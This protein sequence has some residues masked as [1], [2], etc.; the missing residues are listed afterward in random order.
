MSIPIPRIEDY[1]I[2]PITGFLPEKQPLA[3]LPD[4]YSCWEAA[5]SDLPA[6]IHT[7]QLRSIVDKM[8]VLSVGKLRKV[9]EQRRAYS[10][11]G[12][13]A[14]A[15]VWSPPKVHER[16]PRQIAAPLLE[17]SE[18]LGLPPVG[19]FAGLCLWNF[20]TVYPDI[21]GE[22]WDLSNLACITL[23]TG[24]YDEAWFY[25]L[26]VAMER[27]GGPCIGSGLA[28]I[29]AAYRKDKKEV[30]RRLS[31]LAEAIRDLTV[32]LGK[33]PEFLDPYVF[34]HRLR[35]Y[36]AGWK[37]MGKEGLPNGVFYG[38]ETE[39]RQ[40]SGGSNGQSSLVQVLDILLNVEHHA[41]GDR[42]PLSALQGAQS[43][44]SGPTAHGG[45]KES[46]SSAFLIE[47]RNYM[48]R[49]HRQFLVDLEQVANIRDFVLEENDQELT[50]AYDGALMALRDFRS[51]H[52]Q[53]VM[54]YISLQARKGGSGNNDAP[55]TQPQENQSPEPSSEKAQGSSPKNSMGLSQSNG[56]RGTG[57]TLLMPFLKQS[58]DEV[59]DAAIGNWGRNI[60]TN[61]YRR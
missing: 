46:K 58:R 21:P 34:Y 48:P 59:S 24:S 30:S 14:H 56:E 22:Y 15:Y 53:I 6:L 45:P 43:T 16:L 57:G 19:T 44:H 20:R 2:S 36:L 28:A 1:G 18:K 49:E 29:E 41:L 10:V 55:S 12:F 11:L 25:V 39:G 4:E 54:R 17:I 33:M 31:Q 40:Y 32:T 38:D 42:Q 51:K 50:E 35:P 37:N 9:E 13:L 5:V 60:V 61:T 27:Q 7:K 52:I 26:S 23:Y 8:P 3:R 47:M